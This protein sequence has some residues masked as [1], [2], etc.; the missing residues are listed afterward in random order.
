[1]Q[2]LLGAD[3]DSDHNL[4]VAKDLLQIEENYKVPKE[5]TSMGFGE[6]ICSTTKSAGYSRRETRCNWM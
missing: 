6:I 4:L 3:I 5:K 1:V 2:T